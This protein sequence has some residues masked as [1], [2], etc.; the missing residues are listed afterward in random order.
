MKERQKSVIFALNRIAIIP[1]IVLGICVFAVSIYG[2]SIFMEAET[3]DGLKNLAH[4]LYATCQSEGEGEFGLKEGILVKG[5]M[6]FFNNFSVV[7]NIKKIS[8]VDATI[9]YGDTRMLTSVRNAEG[10]RIVGTKAS[11]VVMQHVL[12]NGEEYFSTKV[13]V[14]ESLY[15]GYYIPLKNHDDSIIGMIF[16]G[17][18]REQVMRAIEQMLLLL[19]IPITIIIAATYCITLGYSK[20]IIFSLQKTKEFLGNVAAGDTKVEI[21]PYILS[22]EDEI[23]EMGR[24]AVILQKSITTLVGTDPLTGLGNRRSGMIILANALQEYQKYKNSFAIAIADIDDFKQINDKYGHPAG[25]A[26][27]K[28][29]SVI[30]MNHMDRKGFVS[31]WG[32]EEFLFVYERMNKQRAA[33]HLEELLKNIRT[34][35]ITYN[36]ESIK[37]TITVG[38]AEC[39]EKTNIEELL[40]QADSNLYRGKEDGKNRIIM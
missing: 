4:S 13:P 35:G 7:D 27:L 39:S 11:T 34:A 16:V 10:E 28:E 33:W 26:V 38:L 5:N 6:P 21:D 40:E 25:D 24:F 30:F 2:I 17:K 12:Q 37:V 32:G 8:G 1:L 3:E 22:R 19:F 23:G 20:K 18:A 36:G 14:N 31:R 9:F 29:L 15:F